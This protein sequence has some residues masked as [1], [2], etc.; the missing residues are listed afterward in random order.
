MEELP[1]PDVLIQRR[2]ET[3]VALNIKRDQLDEKEYD[4]KKFKDIMA[5][6]DDEK[7]KAVGTDFYSTKCGAAQLRADIVHLENQLKTLNEAI[8][9]LKEKKFIGEGLNSNET[10]SLRLNNIVSIS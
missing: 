1:F 9:H 5:A 7:L 8:E 2:K 10:L 6:Y 3:N 4:I